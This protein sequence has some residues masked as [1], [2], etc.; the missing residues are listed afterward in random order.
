MAKNE[1]PANPQDIKEEVE[2]LGLIMSLGEE[3]NIEFTIQ[4]IVNQ[5]KK[6]P[7]DVGR[8]VTLGLSLIH[9]LKEMPPMLMACRLPPTNNPLHPPF[10]RDE[11]LPAI[12][13]DLTEENK[14]FVAICDRFLT[15]LALATISFRSEDQNE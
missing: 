12:H 2:L 1:Y 4:Q 6:L 9:H 14:L 15:A 3:K 10:M 5:W 8:I 13:E 11:G 7:Y